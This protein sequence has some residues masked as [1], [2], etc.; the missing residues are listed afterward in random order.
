MR[1]NKDANRKIVELTAMTDD[2]ARLHGSEALLYV[3]LDNHNEIARHLIA[4]HGS[5]S[6]R[7]VEDEIECHKGDWWLV[8][9]TD[10]KDNYICPSFREGL[11]TRDSN[12]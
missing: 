5:T 10:G 1:F 9:H 12:A 2:K 7:Q 8:Y 6:N 11:P 4:V 3:M